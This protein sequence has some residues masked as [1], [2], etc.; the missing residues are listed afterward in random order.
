MLSALRP[1]SPSVPL[2]PTSWKRFVLSP[3]GGVGASRPCFSSLFVFPARRAAF[4]GPDET[5][6]VGGTDVR[7]VDV[8]EDASQL[9]FP[10]GERQS[11][12]E[13]KAAGET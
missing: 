10:K 6:A 13:I 2:R 8:E 1:V 4:G 11:L 12:G 7:A 9:V 5:M 3:P